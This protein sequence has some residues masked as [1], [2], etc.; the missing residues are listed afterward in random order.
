MT[1]FLFTVAIATTIMT[2]GLQAQNKVYSVESQNAETTGVPR[3]VT[4]SGKHSAEAVTNV[5]QKSFTTINNYEQLHNRKP[6]NYDGKPVLLSP[7]NAGQQSI[8]QKGASALMPNVYN[9][10]QSLNRNSLPQN[11]KLGYTTKKS[12]KENV[13]TITFK[14]VGIRILMLMKW[15][16]EAQLFLHLFLKDFPLMI[17]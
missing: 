1:R 16:V 9:P 4:T 12:Q 10:Q 11:L 7:N 6:I 17:I 2:F 14:V 13:A 8:T 15:V 5:P 3:L